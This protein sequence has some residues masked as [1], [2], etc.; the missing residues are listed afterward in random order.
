MLG[1]AVN[2]VFSEVCDVLATDLV[3]DSASITQLDIRDR[4]EVVR[5][6]R[7]FKPDLTINLAALVDLEECE[8]HPDEAFA[9]NAIA[10]EDVARIAAD[11]ESTLVFISTAGIF[12][13]RKQVYND[14]DSPNPISV[15]GQAKYAGELASLL[16]SKDAFV[17]RAGWMMGGGP[18]KDKKFVGKVMRQL[19]CGTSK[20][21]V[22]DDKL[23]T[24]TYTWDFAA[25]MVRVLKSGQTGVYNMVSKG[26]CSRYEVAQC[27]VAILGRNADIE[28]VRVKSA[29]FSAEYFAPRP[30]SEQLD[31]LK[32]R[33]R[34][35]DGMSGWQDNLRDYLSRHDWIG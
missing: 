26:G 34:G 7:D 28:V 9:T 25:N 33:L 15:Y 11:H 16:F 19:K 17:F 23:G 30:A 21:H 29:H 24:P 2:C 35:L 14:Y 20:L 3:G 12:D 6:H 5:V 31:N 32:L 1:E 22:V 27:I 10:A 13:G 8:T 18:A 4:E